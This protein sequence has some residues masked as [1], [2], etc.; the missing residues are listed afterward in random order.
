[1][2]ISPPSTKISGAV[3]SLTCTEIKVDDKHDS[4]TDLENVLKMLSKGGVGKSDGTLECDVEVW[5]KFMMMS[6]GIR[7]FSP[8]CFWCLGSQRLKGSVLGDLQDFL[9]NPTRPMTWEELIVFLKA[10]FSSMVNLGMFGAKCRAFKQK[11]C[12]TILNCNN[13]CKIPQL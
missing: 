10:K 2:A 13:W 8:Q 12:E 3:L 5:R 7:V 6:L 9:D 4:E 11:D 1:M